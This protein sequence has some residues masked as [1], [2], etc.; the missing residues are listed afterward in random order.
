[1][2][3][4]EYFAKRIMATTLAGVLMIS[5]PVTTFAAT[6]EKETIIVSS[7]SDSISEE[8]AQKI[9]Q[10]ILNARYNY[11]TE[12]TTN[13]VGS[14]AVKTA[15]KFLKKNSSKITKI[16]KKY[17]VTVAE[18]KGVSSVVDDILDG[19][20]EVDDSIDSVVYVV[21]DNLI[22]SASD[23]TKQVIANAIRLILPV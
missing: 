23:D 2:K 19:V 17:G 6:P 20:I 1:M 18:G 8:T 13:G 4:I 21:V 15:L 3:K 22:P 9:A 5:S 7:D 14:T 11:D 12:Y 16:L 10:E